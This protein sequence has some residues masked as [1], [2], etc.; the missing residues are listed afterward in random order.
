MIVGIV[1]IAIALVIFPIVLDASDV[2]I[3]H[4]STATYTGLL[5]LVKVFPLIVFVGLLVGG[6]FS[7]WKG[8]KGQ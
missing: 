2:I 3:S 7:L 5:P 4:N 8:M 1:M 6:G